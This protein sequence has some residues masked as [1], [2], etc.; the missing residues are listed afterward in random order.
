MMEKIDLRIN[1]FDGDFGDGEIEIKKELINIP[2][3]H[4]CDKPLIRGKCVIK[5]DIKADW[6]FEEIKEIDVFYWH[7]ECWLKIQNE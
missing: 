5:I 6:D 3:C 2:L 4:E 7:K 1:P